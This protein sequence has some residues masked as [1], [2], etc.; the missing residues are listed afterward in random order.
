M[1]NKLCCIFFIVIGIFVG[2]RNLHAANVTAYDD[3]TGGIVEIFDFDYDTNKL[4]E[5]QIIEYYDFEDGKRKNATIDSIEDTFS[6]ITLLIV[7]NDTKDVRL[8]TIRIE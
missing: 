4:T 5:G 2:M 1:S 3:D 6:L 7:D 8:L